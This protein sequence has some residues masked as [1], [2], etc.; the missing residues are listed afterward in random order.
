[1]QIVQG[2]WKDPNTKGTTWQRVENP[3]KLPGFDPQDLRGKRFVVVQVKDSFYV[4]DMQ[5]QK[6]IYKTG[7]LEDALNYAYFHNIKD[8]KDYGK[9]VSKDRGNWKKDVLSTLLPVL[10]GSI[11]GP[12]IGYYLPKVLK[13]EPEEFHA[14]Y[15]RR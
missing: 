5:K 15:N 7:S 6:F 13:V 14:G 12:I 1:M 9:K 2:L 4:R 11:L 8:D 10:A 3:E